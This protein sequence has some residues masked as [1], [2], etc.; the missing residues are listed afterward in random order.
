MVDWY[1]AQ[2]FK[3]NKEARKSR[4][5]RAVDR[6][7]EPEVLPLS[8]RLDLVPL[9]EDLRDRFPHDFPR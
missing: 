7:L 1:R 4:A 5:A 9:L 3:V 6:G 2:E 8:L